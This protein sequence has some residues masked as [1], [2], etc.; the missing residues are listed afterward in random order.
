[1][2]RFAPLMVASA[3]GLALLLARMFQVQI[4][5]HE[6][7]A[8]EA[9]NLV[10]TWTFDPY[11]RGSI[12]DREG[13]LL[14]H[15]EDVYELDFIW[16]NFR[17]GHPLGQVAEARS[18]LFSEPVDL[19]DAYEHLPAWAMELVRLSPQALDD[20]GRGRA[21]ETQA[22]TIP[23]TTDPHAEWRSSRRG[24]LVFYI[25]AL[26]DLNRNDSESRDI[27]RSIQKLRGRPEYE[28]PFAELVARGR[29][30]APGVVYGELDRRVRAARG[31]L[32]KFAGLWGAD[33]YGGEVEH[34]LEE[35]E[36]ARRDVQN[37]V[38]DELFATA[39]G[40]DAWRLSRA[41][42]ARIDVDWLRGALHWSPERLEDWVDSRGRMWDRVA[43]GV[44]YTHA[45]VHSKIGS[46]EPGSRVLDALASFFAVSE[47][48]RGLL[49]GGGGRW[50][51]VEH[52]V[53]LSE[54]EGVFAGTSP[55]DEDVG[56]AA[57]PFQAD[58]LRRRV[59][60]ERP[61]AGSALVAAALAAIDGSRF[62]ARTIAEVASE[63]VEIARN[64]RQAPQPADRELIAPVLVDW[65]V[66]LQDCIET[67]LERWEAEVGGRLVFTEERRE[68]A[69]DEH[70]YVV[71]DRSSRPL[72]LIKNP[73]YDLVQLVTRYP[74]RYAGMVVRS[75]TRRV[76]VAF[77]EE[78]EPRPIAEQL[79][80]RVRMPLLA[81]LFRQRPQEE[82]LGELRRKRERS[83]SDQAV[84]AHLATSLVRAGERQGGTGL[85]GYF[86]AFLS[87]TN[88]Y[89]ETQGLQDRGAGG[90]N[91]LHLAVRDGED[92][93]LTIDLE[94]QRAA[95]TVL[96]HPAPVPA[97]DRKPD[98]VWRD[99]SVG[100]IV[101]ITPDGDVLAAASAPNR[102][103]EPGPG[104]DG[105]R[106]FAIERTLRRPWAQPPGSVFK[107]FVALW[108]MQFLDFDVDTRF[109]CASLDGGGAGY[110]K[111]HCWNE[112][113]HGKLGLHDALQHSC[114]AYFAAL[115]EQYPSGSKLLEMAHTFGFG[116]PTG[117][118]CLETDARGLSE[119]WQLRTKLS[120][121]PDRLMPEDVH[122]IG[123]GLT[124]VEATPMQVARAY[125][126]L[127][128]GQ[129]PELRLVMSVGGRELPV[130][131]RQLPFE[132]QRLAFVQQA[133]RDVV[134]KGTAA[135]K[136]L[137]EKTLGF[138]LSA[139]T[140]SADY[141]VG[142][143]PSE[144]LLPY[145]GAWKRGM[146]KHTWVAGWFP[147]DEPRAI[148]VVYVHDTSTTSSHGAVYLASQFL[149][150]D[151]VQRFLERASR[152]PEARR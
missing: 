66:R 41:N 100:A 58:E 71:R 16:R 90:R 65:N 145:A 80:G 83:E 24:D 10:R 8:R 19:R 36:G 146:R 132:P 1:M 117:V 37:G 75:T 89:H 111:L 122:R 48:R 101:M 78:R 50:L 6:T 120:R 49:A 54:L 147:S 69:I 55:P 68:S 42:L 140:G 15:D 125:A 139:K 39:A 11:R 91:P 85:E 121:S 119:D 60:S 31:H 14:V 17:R 138:Q 99:H 30:V 126:G 33:G 151:A 130:R 107:P 44:L 127:A 57:L 77:D 97:D 43:G 47:E 28:L 106:A 105:E 70:R 141:R 45:A 93:V 136:G 3:L 34:L 81:D 2:R 9:A 20:F 115:A 27:R 92:L 137:G 26:L 96:E 21:L 46:S 131:S 110:A 35:L 53:V 82:Q 87:G 88:G 25:R 108:A 109:D 63:L 112:W 64:R 118:R 129:L 7:W 116:E 67:V 56:R 76:P 95:Q 94:L 72:R 142:R 128:T 150:S 152:S 5:E 40:F 59:R 102:P 134:R 12:Y 23:A 74:D 38:A 29:D 148:V 13:R 61:L 144:P 4:L 113:G 79:V 86:D 143:V 135:G 133:L 52:L 51:D 73:D 104:Q 149:R 114:N 32:A 84:I 123:N 22:F 103:G 98:L 124:D 62:G 18:V